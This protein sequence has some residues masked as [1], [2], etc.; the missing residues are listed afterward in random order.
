MRQPSF[1]PIEKPEPVRVAVCVFPSAPVAASLLFSRI[2]LSVQTHIYTLIASPRTQFLTSLALIYWYNHAK[3]L[4]A[5]AGFNMS[6]T[7]PF[8]DWDP[9]LLAALCVAVGREPIQFSQTFD[10]ARVTCVRKSQQDHS[11]ITQPLRDA[12]QKAD[13]IYPSHD[14]PLVLAFK[15]AGYEPIALAW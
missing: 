9:A 10:H 11:C 14:N 3:H 15:N 7:N 1:W 4:V 2:C 6:P 8:E 5:H 13:H 12:W